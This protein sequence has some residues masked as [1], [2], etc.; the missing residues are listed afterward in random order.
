LYRD[1]TTN[2][3]GPI[4]KGY[5]LKAV[6][7][8]PRSR[9]IKVPFLCYDTDTDKYNATIGYEGYAYE[10]LA[11]LEDIE[12][13]GDVVTWQDFRTGE[14]QQCLIEEVTFTSITPPDKKLT[15]FGGIVSLTIR[16]V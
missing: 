5:Q 13:S 6:P 14:T 12:A 11:A 16:T 7:A 1:A 4:F 2:S 10:R 3:I 8:T 9:I 15:G